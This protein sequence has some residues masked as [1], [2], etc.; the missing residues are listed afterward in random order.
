MELFTPIDPRLSK[1]L[2]AEWE[3]RRTRAFEP[4]P[5]GVTIA[6]VG[7]R[8]AGKSSLLPHVA[9][10][11]GRPG[12]DLDA[13]VER[14]SK[15]P[16]REWVTVDQAGFRAAERACFESLPRGS[17]V[18]CGGGFLSNHPEALHGCLAVLVPI[19]IET[20]CERLRGDLDRP[21]LHPELSLEEE[22]REV[23]FERE[24]KHRR[25]RAM[26]FVDFLLGA[27]NGKRARRVVTLPPAVNPRDFAFRALHAG[28]ELLEIRTDL[29][30]P[31]ADLAPAARV[32]P[33]LISE[34]EK[35]VPEPWRALAELVDGESPWVGARGLELL[36][37]HAAAP[38]TP[39]EAEEL[40]A[41]VPRGPLV[42]H[43]EPLG[44]LP[45]A[46]RLIETQKRLQARFGEDNATVLA[47]G[48]L[49][50]PF[51]AV[52]A[53][54]NALD[55]LALDATWS[56]APGQRLLA[57]A[58]REAKAG[59]PTRARLAVLGHGI[60]LSRSP[61]IHPQPFDRIELPADADVAVLVQALQPH[62][63]GFAVT[64]PFKRKVLGEVA[65][66]TLWRTGDGFEGDNTDVVG[67]VAALTKLGGSSFTVL[68][69]GGVAD[70]LAAAAIELG[71]G[72]KFVK[73]AEAAGKKLEGS[74][75]W[76]WPVGIEAPEGLKLDGA[77]VGV[78]SYG[79]RG[80]RIA[81]QVR[82]LGGTPVWLGAR[83]FVKQAR[84]QRQRWEAAK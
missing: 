40:W 34:R 78:I 48:P 51:R 12:I 1:S 66:N 36:S 43:V 56:A 83:W 58:V 50:L 22:L 57:D 37:H 6:L 49:A 42:K 61:S 74:I 60:S 4:L 17:L 55:Y 8:A 25:V 29:I 53:R 20:Y 82:A 44:S 15:R 80:H 28:A 75:V 2:H 41:D 62:F 19:T 84:A 69:E 59:L 73:R 45:E 76:S 32:L 54:T 71:V 46:W 13:E 81:K 70:A 63:R 26:P 14:R 35:P 9:K 68:G 23:W 16:L 24:E 39:D 79:S 21:R 7:H 67:A 10:L 65:V 72:M 77:R 52:L 11:L 5:R 31:E 38:M 30:A 3:R 18:A 64:N 33:L 27:A 47:T